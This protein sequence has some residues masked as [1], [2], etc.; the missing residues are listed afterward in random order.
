MLTPTLLVCSAI[1]ALSS[2]LSDIDINDP[3]QKQLYEQLQE[4]QKK[5]QQQQLQKPATP[6]GIPAKPATPVTKPQGLLEAAESNSG[7]LSSFLPSGLFPDLSSFTEYEKGKNNVKSKAYD[8]GNNQIK[9]MFDITG[10]VIKGTD[11]VMTEKST[12]IKRVNSANANMLKQAQRTAGTGFVKVPQAGTTVLSA[13]ESFLNQPFG[14]L[15]LFRP[16]TFLKYIWTLMP[17]YTESP[18]EQGIQVALKNLQ[19]TNSYLYY[20]L[21]DKTEVYK[22]FLQHPK[23]FEYLLAN[24]TELEEYVDHPAEFSE[25][26]NTLNTPVNTLNKPSPS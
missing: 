3:Q 17:W 6:E 15:N 5:K 18:E 16:S 9:N 7:L 26:V 22:Y 10:E 13:A 11:Q 1:I 25:L 21:I 23:A 4:L 2:G 12:Q 8:L 14:F 20:K 19:D 24:P